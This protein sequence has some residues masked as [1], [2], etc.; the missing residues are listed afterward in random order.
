MLKYLLK[1]IIICVFNL[2]ACHSEISGVARGLGGT[3]SLKGA[4]NKKKLRN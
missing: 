1:L 3:T 2:C 4:H